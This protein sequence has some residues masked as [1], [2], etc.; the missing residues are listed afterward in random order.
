MQPAVVDAG[1]G[2]SNF[3]LLISDQPN[4]IGDF[5]ELWV[6]VSGLGLVQGEDEGIIEYQFDEEA[7]DL[8]LT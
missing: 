5:E 8:E 3:R 1:P 6:M 7:H 4:D 2:E